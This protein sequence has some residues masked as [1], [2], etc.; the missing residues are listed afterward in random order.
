MG[1]PRV[2]IIDDELDMR[3]YLSTLMETSGYRPL[4]AG[5]GKE[6]LRLAREKRPHLIIMDIMMPKEGGIQMYRELRS[7]AQLKDIPVI[8][9]SAIAKK[10]FFHSQNLL[11][12]YMGMPLPEPEAYIEK[13]P[14]PEEL[15]AMTRKI[16]SG[17]Q[18]G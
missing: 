17:P 2:L 3:T 14:E 4:V 13:P 12:S 5:D 7:D 10:T 16:L 8:V 6:G 9:V 18:S 1:K 15:Y 11:G